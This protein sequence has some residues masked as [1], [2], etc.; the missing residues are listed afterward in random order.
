MSS[1]SVAMSSPILGTAEE[2]L[3]IIRHKA[4]NKRLQTLGLQCQDEA[5]AAEVAVHAEHTRQ[6]AAEGLEHLRKI[7]LN[8]GD[9]VEHVFD[10]ENHLKEVQW[11]EIF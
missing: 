7:G 11:N 4:A 2:R 1:P 8:F 6:K 5:A 3:A 10:P 9:L